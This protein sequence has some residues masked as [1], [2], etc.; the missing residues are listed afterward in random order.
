[1]FCFSVVES[2]FCFSNVEFITVPAT[3]FIHV[4][5]LR[6]LRSVQ[7]IFVWEIGFDVVCVL[8]LKRLK[9]K[10]HQILFPIQRSL[11]LILEVQGHLHV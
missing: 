6:P 1:M 10:P 2:L 8:K 7:A 3:S 5:D 11:E 4:D 9:H